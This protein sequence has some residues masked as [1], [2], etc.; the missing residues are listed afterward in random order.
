MTFFESIFL[1]EAM[2][3]D[4]FIDEAYEDKLHLLTMRDNENGNKVIGCIFWRDVPSGEMKEW[5]NSGNA[6]PHHKA[7]VPITSLGTGKEV[8]EHWMLVELVCTHR[9]YYGKR[10][11]TMLLASALVWAAKVRFRI[12]IFW[13]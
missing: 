13:N 3:W 8:Y 9:D 4:A 5:L 7:V 2:M 10:V 6:M 12:V 11:A 1:I